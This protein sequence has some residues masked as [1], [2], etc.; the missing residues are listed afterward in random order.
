[1]ARE[2]PIIVDEEARTNVQGLIKEIRALIEARFKEMDQAVAIV[3]M[4]PTNPMV[5]HMAAAF[6]ASVFG[7]GVLHT[8][9]FPEGMIQ[10]VLPNE[11]QIHGLAGEGD[12]G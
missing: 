5:A 3:I 4:G 6:N 8:E 9:L 11:K 10:W 1:M 7:A 12:P 2:N